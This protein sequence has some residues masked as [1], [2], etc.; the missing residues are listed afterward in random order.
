LSELVIGVLRHSP[1]QSDLHIKQSSTHN[2]I[3]SRASGQA[4][5]VLKHSGK[6][7][8][9]RLYQWLRQRT[10]RSY[11]ED[12]D[13]GGRRTIRTEVTVQREQR[14]VVL[15]GAASDGF[16]TC[17]FCGHTLASTQAAQAPDPLPEDSPAGSRNS[18]G[19]A[20][21]LGSNTP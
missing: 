10:T 16:D 18:P 8:G 3:K 12:T 17:P 7:L 20:K 6:E 14:T 11:A 5:P 21:Q 15:G 13:Q 4:A 1:G 9:N 19:L 2:F